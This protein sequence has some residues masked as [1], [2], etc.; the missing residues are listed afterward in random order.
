MATCAWPPE[1][2]VSG[3][4]SEVGGAGT[5]VT[6]ASGDRAVQTPGVEGATSTEATATT[7]RAIRGGG[8]DAG[9]VLDAGRGGGTTKGLTGTCMTATAGPAGGQR[10]EHSPRAGAT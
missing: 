6:T 10:A 3:T 8:E 1:I 4:V 5:C 9:T 7:V 2:T